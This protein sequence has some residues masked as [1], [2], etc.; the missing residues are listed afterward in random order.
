MAASPP[1]CG[2]A[3]GRRRGATPALSLRVYTRPHN[4]LSSGEAR[5]AGR[6]PGHPNSP[7]RGSVAISWRE[8][9]GQGG[10]ARWRRRRGPAAWRAWPGRA[11]E[12]GRA[13][14]GGPRSARTSALTSTEAAA[15]GGAGA[16]G[17]ASRGR[18]RRSDEVQTKR[19]VKG[20]HSARGPHPGPAPPSRPPWACARRAGAVSALSAPPDAAPG[21]RP[22]WG[23]GRGAR[24]PGTQGPHVPARPAAPRLAAPP[25]RK[26]PWAPPGPPHSRACARATSRARF[27]KPAAS[28][29]TACS[30][31]RG[32]LS[33]SA[34]EP[35]GGEGSLIS[36]AVTTQVIFFSGPYR[37]GQR[38]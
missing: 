13:G 16:G 32:C 28:P 17:G 29:A 26:T 15:G 23:W 38:S 21:R 24:A 14:P 8:G 11:G 31:P 22:G 25:P 3:R 37:G 20:R 6:R 27:F 33:R 9:L 7:C 4:L 10:L 2:N 35:L 30:G 19:Y 5:G 36:V 18:R 34:C 1:R 12:G